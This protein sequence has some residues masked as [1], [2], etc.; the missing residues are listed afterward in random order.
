MVN[1]I[2]L[3]RD[4]PGRKGS[5]RRRVAQRGKVGCGMWETG[6][7]PKWKAY[8][9]LLSVLAAAELSGQTALTAP[10]VVGGT[11]VILVKGGLNSA[12]GPVAAPDGSLYFTEPSDNKIYRLDADDHITVLFDEG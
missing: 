9:V 10:D 12:E 6:N 8:F 5:Q 1:N 7:M 11:P 2:T 3:F 4:A